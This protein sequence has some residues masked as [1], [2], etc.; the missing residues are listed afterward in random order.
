MPPAN[1]VLLIDDDHDDHEIFSI[2]LQEAAPFV[3]CYYFDSGKSALN[4]L[5]DDKEFIPDYIFLDLNMPGM[6]GMQLLEIIKQH[7]TISQIPIIVYSTSI[8]PQEKEKVLQLGASRFF[9][10][11]ASHFE[12]IDMLKDV[13]MG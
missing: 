10:K 2:A 8:L 11:P 3:K 12:L 5:M 7:E 9:I 1:S 13:F 4:K 6:S